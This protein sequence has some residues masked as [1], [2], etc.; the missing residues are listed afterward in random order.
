MADSKMLTSASVAHDGIMMPTH[1]ELRATSAAVALPHSITNGVPPGEFLRYGLPL[2]HLIQTKK[3]SGDKSPAVEG[4]ES[5]LAAVAG[6]LNN[7]YRVVDQHSSNCLVTD[8]APLSY[9]RTG[10]VIWQR[11]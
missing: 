4:F 1:E 9:F 11:R 2:A 10:V 5:P 7:A 3:L 6:A 8:A